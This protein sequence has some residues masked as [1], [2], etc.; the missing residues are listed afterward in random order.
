MNVRSLNRGPFE[1]RFRW[2]R[3][4]F[5]MGRTCTVTDLLG[6]ILKEWWEWK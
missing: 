3:L 1:R 2:L 4:R 6:N 5:E